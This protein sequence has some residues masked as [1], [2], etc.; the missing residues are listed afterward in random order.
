MIKIVENHYGELLC[1]TMHEVHIDGILVASYRERDDAERHVSW[2]KTEGAN[3]VDKYLRIVNKPLYHFTAG[4]GQ[5]LYCLMGSTGV[6]SFELGRGLTDDEIKAYVS[7]GPNS[8]KLETL[9]FICI[10]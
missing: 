9:L 3:L 5:Q 8:T 2:L 7:E 4:I 10:E 1:K 6:Y